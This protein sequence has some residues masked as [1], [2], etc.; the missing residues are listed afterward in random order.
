LFKI[1]IMCIIDEIIPLLIPII[2]EVGKGT[3]SKLGEDIWNLIKKP[4]S[5]KRENI[6]NLNTESIR[7]ILEEILKENPKLNDDIKLLLKTS[8]LVQ[9]INNTGATIEKQVNISNINGT[10][11]L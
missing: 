2:G 3:V 7:S 6:S 1:L 11:N 4:F 8:N 10:I 5:T 9:N